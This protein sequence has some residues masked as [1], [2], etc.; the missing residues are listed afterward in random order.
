[1]A[2]LDYLLI[3]SVSVTVGALAVFI[4]ELVRELRRERSNENGG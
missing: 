4:V 3:A 2:T 1:M